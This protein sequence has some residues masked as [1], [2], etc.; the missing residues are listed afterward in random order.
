MSGEPIPYGRQSVDGADVAAVGEVLRGNWL[1]TGPA[2]DVFE[3]ALSEHCGGH[4]AVAVSSGTAALH[5]AYAAAEVGPGTNIVTTPLTF[6]AT[7]S[8]A[9]HLGGDVIFADID[10]ETLLLDPEAVDA[11]ITDRT[12]AIVPVDYA[13]H[14]ADMDSFR[15]IAEQS[16]SVLIEDAAHSIGGTY[17]NRVVGDLADMTTFSFHPVKTITTAEGGAVIA[18][19]GRY[20]DALRR[21]R[22]HGLVRNRAEQRDPHGDWHQEVHRIGLNYRMPDVLAALGTS[23]LTK[24]ER[25]VQRRRDLVAR[26]RN[27]LTGVD[28]LRLLRECRD[29]AP[30]WHLFPVRVLDGRRKEVFNRMRAVGIGVQVHYLPVH[31]HP[32][33]RDLGYEPRT[34]PVAEAAYEELLSLPL[35]PDLTD[36][37]QDRVVGELRN[38]LGS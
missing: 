8:T 5:A 12:R 32:A 24:L 3:R 15:T 9:L 14:P 11:V 1:T 23:Q 33:F 10:D 19:D 37:Q 7:A 35:Y 2:V 31:L 26:Y 27:L 28:G 13:G 34:C 36:E 4:P 17:R 30:A 18:R 22:N 21:F 6:A 20:V 29:V 38:I 25:F 16:G